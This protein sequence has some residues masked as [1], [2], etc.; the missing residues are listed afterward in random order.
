M[1][2]RSIVVG[3]DGSASA[4]ATVEWAITHA[5]RTGTPLLLTY[6]FDWPIVP[7][8]LSPG[9]ASWPDTT[10]RHDAQTMIDDAVAEAA[11]SHPGLIVT[12]TLLDGPP[13][14]VLQEESRHASLVVLGSRGH[15][16]FAD[17]LVGSTSFAVSAHAHCPVVVVRGDEQRP[18]AHL[19]AGVDGSPGSLLALQYALEQAADRGVPLHV[20]RAWT[21]PTPR[22]SPP[23][24]DQRD[25]TAAEKAAL[26]ELLAGWQEKY[27]DVEV[28]TEVV[29]DNPSRVLAKASRYA[30]LVVVGSRGR[31]G[32]RGL[33]LG[34]VSQQLL[35]H[36]HCPVAVIREIPPATAERADPV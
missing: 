26:D 11:R 6:A 2:S 8:A 5:T 33:L 34:S 24:L 36:S 32:F 16:G 29:A 9:P 14:V 13:A 20:I 3:Y 7:A 17:L 4:A 28:T 25:I 23:N 30:Q 10:A 18:G 35:H 21:P 31:G 22:W 19:L 27:P 1:T 12:G 15:G